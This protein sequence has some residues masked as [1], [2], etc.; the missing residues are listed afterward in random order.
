MLPY[1]SK[2]VAAT[3][4]TG[5]GAGAA[6]AGLA[7]AG[8]G[9]VYGLRAGMAT[10][11]FAM[12]YTNEVMDAISHFGYDISDPD[13]VA[14]ALQDNKVWSRGRERGLKRG[15]PIAIADYLT[16]SLAGKV[17]KVG[18]V[19]SKA[20]R[21]GAMT[22]ERLLVDPLGEASGEA[23]AQ[24]TVGDELDFKEIVAEAGGGL[25]NNTSNMAINL[26]RETKSKNKV[27]LANKLTDINFISKDISSDKQISDWSNNMER[28]GKIKPEVNQR[29]QKNVG[30]RRDAK[31]LQDAAPI[32][33]IVYSGKNRAVRARIM[34]LLAAKEELSSTQNRKSVFGEKIREIDA[35]LASTVETGN[36]LPQEEQVVLAG[37]GVLSAKEQASAADVRE[38]LP[39]YAIKKGIRGK[40]VPVSKEE[41]LKKIDESSADE[42]QKINKRRCHSRAKHRG[43]SASR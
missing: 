21:I 28:L 12:E 42:L 32:E 27:D 25:G 10:T 19:A 13:S 11:M 31:D 8:A 39:E 14:E 33:R 40:M 1:G 5:A 43:A 35:E 9:A 37:Q 18:S 30:L 29:I 4:A 34:T 26:A 6:A 16:A 20:K 23:I 7:G 36:L 22:A 3:T 38:V 2:I 15:I 24:V 41:F 17:I